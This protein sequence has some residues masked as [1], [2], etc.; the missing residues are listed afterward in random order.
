[1]GLLQ[2]IEF[3]CSLFACRHKLHFFHSDSS[4]R[5][6]P[7]PQ[8]R[9]RLFTFLLCFG[10]CPGIPAGYRPLRSDRRNP[11]S[12]PCVLWPPSGSGWPTPSSCAHPTSPP[13]VPF[14]FPASPG[15]PGSSLPGPPPYCSCSWE[16]QERSSS[17]C[18]LQSVP[19]SWPE[20]G[21]ACSQTPVG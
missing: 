7:P 1:H 17:H 15:K 3:F 8:R 19:E 6:V 11:F 10:F 21:A 14:F 16:T 20:C 2:N 9:N 18:T 12:F 5:T 4:A 13:A